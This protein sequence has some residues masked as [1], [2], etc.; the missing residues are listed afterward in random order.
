MQ[1]PVLVFAAFL[2]LFVFLLLALAGFKLAMRKLVFAAISFVVVFALAFV[3]TGWA[4]NGAPPN[5]PELVAGVKTPDY[6]LAN[7]VG[8]L[9][10]LGLACLS[11]RYFVTR[12][13]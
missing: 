11:T 4:T 6:W 13:V 8:I 3:G 2:L 1:N 9:A 12:K 7:W 10:G 5:L